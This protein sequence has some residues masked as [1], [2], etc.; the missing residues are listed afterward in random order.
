MAK[1][2]AFQW[3]ARDWLAG[4]AR[5]WSLEEQGAQALL[6]SFAWIEEGLPQD[7][8][9]LA[10]ILAL[11]QTE[12]ERIWPAIEREWKARKGKL[13]NPTQE[14]Y[15]LELKGR[16]DGRVRAGKAGGE[17]KAR[18]RIS[19]DMRRELFAREGASP[20][21]ISKVSCHYCGVELTLDWSR[22]DRPR[23]LDHKGGSHPELDYVKPLSKGGPNTVENLVPSCLSCNRSR[24]DREQ[25]S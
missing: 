13:I 2:P 21:Q 19:L 12:F 25:P 7:P 20:G 16:R 5:R 11:P 8:S 14:A 22:T 9:I 4:P 23:L 18:K 1:P 24:C 10:R 6:L 15:R 17:A 3:Y